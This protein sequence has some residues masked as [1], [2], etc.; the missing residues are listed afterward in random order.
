MARNDT[1]KTR[2]ARVI[3][4]SLVFPMRAKK[5][6]PRLTRA[7]RELEYRVSVSSAGRSTSPLWWQEDVKNAM[8]E[9]QRDPHISRGVFMGGL[10]TRKAISEIGRA[11]V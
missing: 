5:A 4:F 6:R 2:S 1:G 3:A 7:Y 8:N 9:L 11:H 10:E